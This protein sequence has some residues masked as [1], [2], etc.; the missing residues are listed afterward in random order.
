MSDNTLNENNVIVP[1]E[2]AVVS[3]RDTLEHV[4][5][6]IIEANRQVYSAVNSAMVTAY[7]NIGKQLY[8]SCGENDRA[9]YGKRLMQFLSE[10][11]T[12]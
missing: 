4:R 1:Y 3:Q 9:G 6:Y 11:L 7:W 10:K 5:G 2:Q 8:I 12:A